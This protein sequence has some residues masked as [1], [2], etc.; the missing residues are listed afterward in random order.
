MIKRE[1]GYQGLSCD[2]TKELVS[3][4]KNRGDLL[5]VNSELFRI[6]I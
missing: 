3:K 4:L 2:S 5:A 1:W 6:V